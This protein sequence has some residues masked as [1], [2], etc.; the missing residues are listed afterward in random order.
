MELLQMGRGVCLKIENLLHVHFILCPRPFF[1]IIEAISKVH[2]L[3]AKYSISS[4]N[5]DAYT[6]YIA[7]CMPSSLYTPFVIPQFCQYNYTMYVIGNSTLTNQIFFYRDQHLRNLIINLEPPSFNAQQSL[8]MDFSDK[9]QEILS[10]LN[11]SQKKAI[12]KV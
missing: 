3:L 6:V 7:S 10:T 5:Y 8:K 12:F 2:G 1:L 4:N 9:V 11:S